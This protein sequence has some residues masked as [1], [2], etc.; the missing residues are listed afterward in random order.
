[1]EN[2]RSNRAM[3]LVGAALLALVV[4]VMSRHT[5]PKPV[6]EDMRDA[7]AAA[8]VS[9]AMLGG[10]RVVQ[11]NV[12]YFASPSVA[13]AEAEKAMLSSRLTNVS[14]AM[15]ARA[16]KLRREAVKERALAVTAQ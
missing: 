16:A 2:G 14:K 11:P 9:P 5:E 4:G 8:P 6:P 7:V 12:G 13:R 3:T 15:R 10:A 1:M